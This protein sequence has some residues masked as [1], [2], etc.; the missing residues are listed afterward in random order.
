M[1]TKPNPILTGII[2]GLA[3]A[4]FM[5]ADQFAPFAALILATAAL[6]SIF[7]AGLG[8]GLLSSLV[9]LSVAS[10]AS[11]AYSQDVSGILFVAI[12]LAP[13]VVMSVLAN[14]A[15]P[16]H[17][18]GGPETALAWFPLSDVLLAGAI[19]TAGTTIFSLLMVQDLD[20]LYDLIAAEGVRVAGEMSGA[21]PLPADILPRMKAML[22]ILGPI[23][24][25]AGNMLLLFF[26]YYAA[27]RILAVRGLN[28]RPREDI[29]AA[30]RMNRLAIVVFI[31]GIVLLF[32]GPAATV[33]G[34]SLTGA[35]AAGFLMAGFAVIHNAVRGKSWGLPALIILYLVTFIIPL[36]A[37][38]V[39]LAGGIANPRRA[40][41][42]TP[43]KPDQTP[44]NQ[45]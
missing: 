6:S 4:I 31:F 24:M 23:S 12:A 27:S 35:A 44:A 19:L 29:P 33:V 13:A 32:A 22:A 18:I 42:L 20:K 26:G 11:A 1:N 7:F 21:T 8:F 41:A 15:R 43:R 16:A 30:L 38:I 3:A 9:A 36:A 34:A 28:I 5:A 39:I 10:V 17:E 40:V 14:L 45:P 2:A 25:S 37:L